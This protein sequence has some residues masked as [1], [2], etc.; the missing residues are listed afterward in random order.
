MGMTW[1]AVAPARTTRN[2]T[3]TRWSTLPKALSTIMPALYQP[4]RSD[5]RSRTASACASHRRTPTRASVWRSCAGRSRRARRT[6]PSAPARRGVELVVDHVDPALGLAPAVRAPAAGGGCGGGADGLPGAGGRP[7]PRGRGRQGGRGRRHCR[8]RRRRV[9]RD[10]R[11]RLS[12]P[13]GSGDGDEQAG[14]AHRAGDDDDRPTAAGPTSA[15]VL[16][17][18]G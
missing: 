6:G 13:D 11:R 8:G 10:R 16:A 18:Y 3:V 9:D 15:K 5:R 17:G 1:R 14:E 4:G 7:R 2:R 12:R